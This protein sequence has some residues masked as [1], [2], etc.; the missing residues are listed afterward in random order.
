MRVDFGGFGHSG[1]SDWSSGGIRGV[2]VTRSHYLV[3]LWSQLA[4]S[5]HRLKVETP[6]T[7]GTAKNFVTRHQKRQNPLRGS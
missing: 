3:Y 6:H 4:E 1:L 7:T 5:S 2:R